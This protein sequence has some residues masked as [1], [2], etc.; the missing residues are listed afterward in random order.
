MKTL[1][2]FAALTLATAAACSSASD[3]SDGGGAPE[4]C[5]PYSP[6]LLSCPKGTDPPSYKNDVAPIIKLRCSP[7]HF[8]GGISDMIYD[9]STHDN[10]SNA[11][12]SMLNQFAACNMPPI[13]G[14]SLYG[15]APGTVPGLTAAQ[16]DTIVKWIGCGAPNN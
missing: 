9:L 5:P 1:L 8:E 2:L 3:T 12:T 10:V 6:S 7:C 4:T 16:L 14:N 11:S 13:H 15:I